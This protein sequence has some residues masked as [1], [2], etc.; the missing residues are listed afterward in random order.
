MINK[1]KKIIIL[2][3]MIVIL[4]IGI[5]VYVILNR[6][7]YEKLK[8]SVVLIRV[9][10]KHEQ[11]IS[12]GSGVVVFKN[13]IILTNAH[14][15]EDNSK[16]EITT[17]DNKNYKVKGIIG[18]DKKKD[19][20]ILKIE[21]NTELRALK[22]SKNTKVG[23]KVIAIGSPLG[24]K[25]IVSEGIISGY[26]EDN[27]KV[28]Q[29]TAPIS[30]GSSG[31]AL[32]DKKGN[33]LGITYA[34][35][36][37]GQNLNLAI[38]ISFFEKEYQKVK[39]NDTISTKYYS[40]LNYNVIKNYNGI[41]ILKYALSDKYKNTQSPKTEL[42]SESEKGHLNIYNNVIDKNYVDSSIKI[43]SGVSDSISF[44]DEGYD[45]VD[46]NYYSIVIAKVKDKKHI[47]KV[48]KIIEDNDIS[49]LIV[50]SDYTVYIN[51]DYLYGLT[52]KNYDDCDSIKNVLKSIAK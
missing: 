33:L 1:Y 3:V 11:L 20:A 8:N 45:N 21:K 52:C 19:I 14:V 37:E 26:F 9:Y 10:D 43:I 23:N 47:N 49:G 34:S 38:P 22:I 2:I 31:G 17:E 32:L 30:H 28:Y 25:N 16:I 27:I 46:G 5:T 15:V 42:A 44:L 18:Y 39:D 6:A 48:K 40:L 36:E 29:H 41:K 24:L 13:D 35:I 4:I 7:D 51:N 50:N 12:S